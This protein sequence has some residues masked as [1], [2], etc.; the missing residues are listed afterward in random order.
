MIGLLTPPFGVVLFVLERVTGVKVDRIVRS[1]VPFYIPLLVSLII[2]ILVP[3]TV[4][5]LPNFFL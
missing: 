1:M 4:M 2:M 5:F 3:A